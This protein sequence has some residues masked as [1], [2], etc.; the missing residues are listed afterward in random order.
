MNKKLKDLF[1][2]TKLVVLP[3]EFLIICISK[4]HLV[5]AKQKISEFED[6]FFSFV[7]EKDEITFILSQKNWQQISVD[8]NNAKI[9]KDYKIITFDI[10]LEWNIVGYLAEITKLLSKNKISVGVVS[11][12]SKDHILVKKENVNKT[13]ETLQKLIEECKN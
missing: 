6:S 3:E 4:E 8:F 5:K 13:L 7:N 11:T 12:Y 9:E 10:P 1:A 2:K